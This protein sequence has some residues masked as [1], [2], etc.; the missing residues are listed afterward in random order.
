MTTSTDRIEEIFQDARELQADALDMLAQGRIRNAAEKAWGATKRATDT[1][2]LA[3]TGEEPEFS[4]ET[5]HGLRMLESLDEAVWEAHLVRRYYTR[6][7]SFH[8]HCFYMGLC[9]PLEETERRIRETGPATSR[10]PSAWPKERTGTIIGC[11]LAHDGQTGQAA[12]DR[13]GTAAA[14]EAGGPERQ[15]PHRPSLAPS[16]RPIVRRG[17]VEGRT[18]E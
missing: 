15:P 3:R 17:R 8:G 1:L 11:W 9:D 6:Q 7:G 14:V 12:L 16:R 18:L 5:A 13:R 4:P 10:T 2:I